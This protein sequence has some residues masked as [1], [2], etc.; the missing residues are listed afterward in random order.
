[1]KWVF[2]FEA[3]GSQRN[4]AHPYDKRNVACNVGFRNID[5]NKTIIRKLEYDDSPYGEALQEIQTLLDEC[6]ILVGFNIKYDLAWF[7]RYGLVL[8][9][10]T[11]VFD[12]QLAYFI[13]T[14]QLNQYPSLDDVAEFV[15][16]EKKL[17]IVKTEYW[18]KGLDTN[19][20]PYEILEEYL[21]QDLNVTL[22][23]Y[24]KLQEIIAQQSD[25]MQKLI[26]VSMQD[27]V[28]LQDIEKNGLLVNINKSI[29]KG[30]K[31]VSEINEI[32]KWFCK[33]TGHDWFNTGSGDH[34]SAMLYG[35]V[36]MR[37]G[38][39]EYTFTYKHGGTAQKFRSVKVPVVFEGMFKPLEKSELA[40]EGFYATNQ[41]TLVT[42]L[43]RA[44]G[45]Y[46]VVL[47]KLIHRAKLDQLRGTY[48]HG[49]P[50]HIDKMGWTNNIIHSSFNQCV[51]VSGRLSSAK[52]NVQNI[53]DSVKEVF[54]TR[55]KQ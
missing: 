41:P 32:D 54:I 52:P 37:D 36:I 24:L 12:C 51:A 38:K 7:T 9:P 42:L 18:D 10:K 23:V 11:R 3:T 2:D 35:G 22:Q 8:N 25:K 34:L 15:G 1:M 14:N 5:T 21:E 55:F 49:Y 4:K 31:L 16:V 33:I 30:N 46:A 17:D 40:K 19:E 39:E 53:E 6:T 50:K 26:S 45:E 27:S 29:E 48:Y 20:V 44:K 43:E 47:E 28:V 13:L